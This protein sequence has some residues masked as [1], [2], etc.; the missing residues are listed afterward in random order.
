MVFNIV[1]AAGLLLLFKDSTE[2]YLISPI[3]QKIMVEKSGVGKLMVEKSGVERSQ[4]E[5]SGVEMSFNPHSCINE[6]KI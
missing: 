3:A 5:N 6:Q 1:V 4:V 2:T